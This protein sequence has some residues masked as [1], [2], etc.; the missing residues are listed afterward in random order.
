M[1]LAVSGEREKT[2]CSRYGVRMTSDEVQA[3]PQSLSEDELYLALDRAVFGESADLL[4]QQAR[5]AIARGRRLF[6]EWLE[7]NRSAFCSDPA[8]ASLQSTAG[9]ERSAEAAIV[10]D[11]LLTIGGV[12]P[13]A[14]LAAL[15]LRR[16]LNA[17]C[18][19]NAAA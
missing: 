13:V 11:V 19:F 17:I 18:P 15:I 12:L 8:V 5:A 1:R 2:P 16:G 3:D 6:E 9:I 14:T 4:P 7:V 10:I